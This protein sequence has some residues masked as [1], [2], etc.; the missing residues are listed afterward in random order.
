[1]TVMERLSHIAC[2]RLLTLSNLIPA[3][4]SGRFKHQLVIPR[5]QETQGQNAVGLVLRSLLRLLPQLLETMHSP[6]A[7]PQ[8]G[9]RTNNNS[10]DLQI[11]MAFPW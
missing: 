11:L 1:M 4:P 7:L 8:Q 9:A 10:A 6:Q 3:I 5:M 2:L